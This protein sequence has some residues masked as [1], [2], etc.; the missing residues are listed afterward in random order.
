MLSRYW[1]RGRRRAD[2]QADV[3]VDRHS[4]LEWASALALLL[5]TVIDW[6]WT[7]AHLSRGVEEVNPLMAWAW[8]HGGPLGFAALKLGVTALGV[9]F[10][11][12]HARFRWTTRLM[13]FAVVT[14]TLL[15]GVHAATEIALA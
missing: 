4:G 10:L 8:A 15:L 5:L 9:A 1:L 12:R 7:Q 6:A 13:P 3:Y 2:G 11:L 14:Y